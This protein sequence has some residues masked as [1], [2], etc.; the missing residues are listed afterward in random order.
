MYVVMMLR[1]VQ[2]VVTIRIR[3]RLNRIVEIWAMP[4]K[5]SVVECASCIQVKCCVVSKSV[6]RRER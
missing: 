1:L 5:E 3:K 2:S 4:R 6:S